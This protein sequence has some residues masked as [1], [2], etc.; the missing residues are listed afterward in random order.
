MILDPSHI[1]KLDFFRFKTHLTHKNSIFFEFLTHLTHTNSIFSDSGPISHTQTRVS[2][3]LDPSHTQKLDFFRVLYPSHIQKL[4][5]LKFWIHLTY[6]NSP[7][8]LEM[9]QKHSITALNAP[10][11]F[12]KTH[13]PLMKI[14]YNNHPRG[15]VPESNSSQK[16]SKNAQN[17]PKTL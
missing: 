10:E 7:T 14:S 1:Q 13:K 3:I 2:Q 6:K 5:F 11:L 16:V 4:D 12:E 15:I 9:T 17:D 8:K